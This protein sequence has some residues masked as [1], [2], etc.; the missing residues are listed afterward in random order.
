MKLID[1][2]FAKSI[3]PKRK[4]NSYKGSFGTLVSV[5]GSVGFAGAAILSSKAA[6]R[7]GVGLLNVALPPNIYSIVSPAVPEAI[8]TLI[9]ENDCGTVCKNGIKTIQNALEH[10]S[11]CLVGCGLGCNQ[12]TKDVVLSIL[13]NYN[14]P[15]LLDAD[16]INSICSNIDVLM[17]ARS[18]IVLTPHLGEMARILNTDVSYINKYSK[19]IALEFSRK[20]RKVLVLKSSKTIVSS[21]NGDL[22]VNDLEN[23]GLSKGGSGDVLSGIIAS[24]LAQGVEPLNSAILGVYVHSR[25]GKICSR[26]FSERA[27]LPSDVIDALPELFL[28]L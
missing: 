13:K 5:C 26:R 3:I 7:C 1:T 17:S 25:A 18:Q 6:I 21:P 14:K 11:A 19:K 20:Y 24:F 4:L 2:N 12:D 15:I 22:F 23:S 28:N 27:M 9:D 10:S 8:C 16:G